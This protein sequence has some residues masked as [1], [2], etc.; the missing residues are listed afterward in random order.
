MEEVIVPE[1]MAV[2][3]QSFDLVEITQDIFLEGTQ[4]TKLLSRDEVSDIITNPALILDTGL[5]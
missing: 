2:L 3:E 5:A 1:I 4:G